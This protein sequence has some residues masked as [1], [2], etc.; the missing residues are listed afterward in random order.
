MTLAASRALLRDNALG[1]DPQQRVDLAVDADIDTLSGLRA[2][3]IQP[4]HIRLLRGSRQFASGGSFFTP[5]DPSF[6]AH[7]IQQSFTAIACWNRPKSAVSMAGRSTSGDS[8]RKS[9]NVPA[10]RRFTPF[11]GAEGASRQRG[12]RGDG[13]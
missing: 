8:L 5:C 1:S 11:L 2:A 3:E 12:H 13:A 4:F 6:A 10:R 7:D 9:K